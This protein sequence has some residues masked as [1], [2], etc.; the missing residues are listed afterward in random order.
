MKF[1]KWI[2]N[3]SVPSIG[4]RIFA[5]TNGTKGYGDIIDTEGDAIIADT[6]WGR[7]K[8][9]VQK[10]QWDNQEKAWQ[11]GVQPQ[12]SQP[13]QRYFKPGEDSERNGGPFAANAL[14]SVHDGGKQG[15]I[16]D[17]GTGNPVVIRWA[18]GSKTPLDATKDL[19]WDSKQNMWRYKKGVNVNFRA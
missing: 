16:G 9:P 12:Q 3:Q 19:L 4:D 8:V 2:E 7:K 13:Q 5:V 17:N 14:D 11:V 10:L 18:N 15:V 1:R 6:Q